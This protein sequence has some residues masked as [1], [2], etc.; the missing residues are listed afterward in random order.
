MEAIMNT[1]TRAVAPWLVRS[2]W[3]GIIGPILFTVTFLA[4]EAFRV[5]EYSPMRETVSA[6]EAGPNG[7]VQQL[8]FVVFGALTMA[9]AVG[10]HGGLQRAKLG[11]VGPALFFVSGI[12]GML[13]AVFPLREDAAGVTYDPGGHF[14]VGM[15]FFASSAVALVVVSFRLAKDPAWRGLA[16]Y[17]RAAGIA[18]LLSNP[19]MV[20]LVVPDDAPLHDWAGL[21]QRILVL[22]VLFPAR[23]ALSHRLLHA[24]RAADGPAVAAEAA[25]PERIGSPERRS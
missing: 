13:A 6:L 5:G 14:A 21:A 15:T 2:G 24:A 17:A 23:I 1:T 16:F 25:R 22:G 10:L 8:N 9:F 3:A 18:L 11:V 12:G 4:Q 19:V 7:W 20:V